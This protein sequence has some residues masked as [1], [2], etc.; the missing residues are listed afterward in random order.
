MPTH[1]ILHKVFCKVCLTVCFTICLHNMPQYAY[2]QYP[3]HTPSLISKIKL[4]IFLTPL[5]E[6]CFFF[7]YAYTL[8]AYTQYSYAVC[9]TVCLTARLC[10]MPTHSILHTESYQ[11]CLTLCLTVCFTICLHSMHQYAYPQY[12]RHRPSL[13]SKF[14]NLKSR[15]KKLKYFVNRLLENCFFLICLHIVWLHTVCLRSMPHS[16]PHSMPMQYA[17]PEYPTQHPTQCASEYASQYVYKVC[18]STSDPHLTV[19]FK[20]S[21]LKL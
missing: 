8:Y 1:I 10:N 15:N 21:N 19:S 18:L 7:Y 9:L 17:Y 2:T 16:V 5:L 20:I 6:N 4:K 11:V 14:H 13:I 12:P 3:R